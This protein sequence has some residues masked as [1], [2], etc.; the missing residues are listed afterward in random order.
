MKY[1]RGTCKLPLILSTDGSGILKW[2]VDASFTVHPNMQGHSGGGLSFRWRFPIV[3]STKQKLNTQSS[4]ETEVVG[5][6]DFMPAICWTQYFLKAQGYKVNDNI[7]FQ[8]NRSV[9]LLAKN[10]KALS[11]KHTKH[12]NIWYF[13]ITDQIAKGDL[14]VEW[15][16]TADMVGDY[17]TKPLQ[18]GHCFTNFVTKLW[19]WPVFKIHAQ[20]L[21]RNRW[22]RFWPHKSRRCGATGV[23]WKNLE[24]LSNWSRLV[25]RYHNAHEQITQQ[26]CAD[27]EAL[28]FGD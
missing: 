23:C 3:S 21:Q 9:M 18:G 28:T 19:A 6:D 17:M 7:L 27:S 22:I 8:D 25:K 16:P 5:A 15:C 11:T 1:I 4:T 20:L 2:W 12:I 24:N 14:T 10:G 26:S 13:F